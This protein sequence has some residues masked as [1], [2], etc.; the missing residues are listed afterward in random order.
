MS[1]LTHVV[2]SA[3]SETLNPEPF[4]PF[5]LVGLR[6]SRLGDVGLKVQNRGL[7]NKNRVLGYVI[8]CYAVIV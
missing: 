3:S 8:V 5:G 6:A 4:S 1:A 2:L 7:N